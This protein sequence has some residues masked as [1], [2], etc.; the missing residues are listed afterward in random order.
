VFFVVKFFGC[1]PV[2]V[3]T[4]TGGFAA[5]DFAVQNNLSRLLYEAFAT[6]M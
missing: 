2:R 5:S 1:L 3:R 4:Q 6:G